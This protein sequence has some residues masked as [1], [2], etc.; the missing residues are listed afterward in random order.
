VLQHVLQH[1]LVDRWKPERAPCEP[2]LSSREDTPVESRREHDDD[3]YGI[4]RTDARSGGS[5]S[6]VSLTESGHTHGSTDECAANRA[7]WS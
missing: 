2:F 1:G 7:W 6:P 4:I 3:G 5:T